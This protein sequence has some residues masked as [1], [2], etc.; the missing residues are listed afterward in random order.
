[1]DIYNI[2]DT[3]IEF[4]RAYDN[5]VADNKNEL[6]PYIGII[7]LIGDVKY[8]A[9][10]TSPKPKHRRMHNDKDFRKIDGGRLGA[11]NFNNMIPVPDEAIIPLRISN[12]QNPQYRRLLQ[13]QYNAILSDWEP[14]QNTAETLHSL[15]FMPEAELSRRDRSVKSRCC[16]LPLLESVY[17]NW[18]P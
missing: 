8:Y 16:N 12:E 9:P 15:L 7:L 18:Q 6:R 1:M 13:N 5:R 3:Y 2:K 10:F 17:N 4:I 11:I 14:I